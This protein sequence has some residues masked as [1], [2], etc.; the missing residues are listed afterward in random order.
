MAQEGSG[1]TGCSSTRYASTGHVVGTGH[2]IARQWRPMLGPDTVWGGRRTI[3]IRMFMG[4]SYAS[5]G[6]CTAKRRST[7]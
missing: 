1:D 7:I 6:H 2:F 5:T 4:M 3:G